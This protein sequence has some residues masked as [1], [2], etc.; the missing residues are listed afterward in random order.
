[1]VRKW[2]V[3]VVEGEHF[4]EETQECKGACGNKCI[5]NSLVERIYSDN[6]GKSLR[7]GSFE[8]GWDEACGMRMRVSEWYRG[9][10]LNS[11]F[12]CLWG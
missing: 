6:R 12:E 5:E 1:M 8:A 10:N 3:E 9:L 2:V 4:G 11:I 7:N